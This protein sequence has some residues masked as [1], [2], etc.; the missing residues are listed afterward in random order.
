[1]LDG[2]G[3]LWI[4]NA[5]AVLPVMTER[6]MPLCVV[7]KACGLEPSPLLTARLVLGYKA[8]QII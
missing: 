4:F 1:M 2:G 6:M 3:Q 5:A 8:C 7:S